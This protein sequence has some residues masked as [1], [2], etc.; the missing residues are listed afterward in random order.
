MKVKD[1]MTRDV[2]TVPASASLKEAAALLV[3]RGISGVPVVDGGTVVGVFSER[4]LLFKE[5][6]RPDR[7]RWLAWLLDPVAVADR[8]KL[9]ATTVAE[10]MTSPALTIEQGE[11]VAAAA[12]RML[13]AGVSRLPVI[14]D[15][16]LVGIITRA[17]LV[18]AFVRP[19]AVIAKEIHEEIIVRQMYLQGVDVTVE[20]GHAHITGEIGNAFDRELLAKLVARAPGVVDVAFA[21]PAAV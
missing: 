5:Q 7:S 9:E 1:A 6:G 20:D 19:D 21:E 15:G 4:D 11:P 10:A 18:R 8:P 16:T 3:L 17:D 14:A 13:D 2:A 12:K